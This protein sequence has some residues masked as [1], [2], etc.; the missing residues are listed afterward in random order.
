MLLL[1]PKLS[2]AALELIAKEVVTSEELLKLPKQLKE[3]LE[4]YGYSVRL[5]FKLQKT[6]GMFGVVRDLNLKRR[7][8]LPVTEKF[9][10]RIMRESEYEEMFRT[11]SLPTELQKKVLTGI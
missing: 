10:R 3:A 9:I 2:N 5:L 4:V 1:S 6:T 7:L 11:R 8:R